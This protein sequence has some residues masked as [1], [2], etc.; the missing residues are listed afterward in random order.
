MSGMLARR[1]TRS[2]IGMRLV[3]GAALIGALLSGCSSTHAV[4]PS[5]AQVTALLAHHASA[6]LDRSRS[7]FASDL[8]PGKAA[9]DF[10]SRQLAEFDN[11]AGVPLTSWTY[12]IAEPVTDSA[13][14]AAATKRLGAPATIVHLTLHYQLGPAD[15]QPSVHDLWWTVVRR[16]GHTYLAGDSDLGTGGGKA[17]QAPWDFGPLVV[18][19][20]TAS[21]VLA[22]PAQAAAL[23]ALTAAADSAV[24]V[25]AS[26]VPTG[27]AKHVVVLVPGSETELAAQVQDAQTA[28]LTDVSAETTFDTVGTA[29]AATGP[30][31]L[32]NPDVL[33]RLTPVGRRIVLQHE[34]THIATASLTTLGTRSWVVEGFAE[35][36]A[37]QGTG[38]SV[39]DAARELAAQVRHGAM[40]P[41]DLPGD[42]AFTAGGTGAAVAYE[43]AWLA[44]RYIA[45][46][47]GASG[48][49]NF[50]RTVNSAVDTPDA[51]V[52]QALQTVLHET[53]A[54][55]VA[56]WGAY[57]IAQLR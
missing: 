42:A 14:I 3:L 4:P 29:G 39:P 6:L 33:N 13:A 25:V 10:R 30:R 55:F 34:I 53:R 17:W 47:V 48:L 1:G 22:H 43:E 21:L 56:Q 19:H 31:V 7:A 16:D 35:Y 57:M 36:V 2:R 54:G 38:Q 23:P 28:S 9:A 46:R 20:G 40:A 8:D 24:R 51:A 18:Q 44:C 37:N 5:T 15:P 12:T 52:D 26:V 27:W 11:L 45:S 50:Y 32:V 41:S 49:L